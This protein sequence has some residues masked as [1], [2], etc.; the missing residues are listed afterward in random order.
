MREAKPIKK[1]ECRYLL[2]VFEVNHNSPW[3]LLNN[4]RAYPYRRVL[5]VA[6]TL[7]FGVSVFS[8]ISAKAY[9]V[10]IDNFI[11]IGN[12]NSITVFNTIL[13]EKN[14]FFS[15]LVGFYFFKNIISYITSNLLT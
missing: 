15:M 10:I 4:R 7:I 2:F 3:N 8:I 1:N 11:H 5:Y 9:Q 12:N 14:I 13:I 6:S